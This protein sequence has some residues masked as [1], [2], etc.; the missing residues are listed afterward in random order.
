MRSIQRSVLLCCKPVV[1]ASHAPGSGVG[2]DVWVVQSLKGF[3][4]SIFLSSPHLCSNM[5]I[6]PFVLYIICSLVASSLILCNIVS[7]AGFVDFRRALCM[8]ALTL[9]GTGGGVDET[10]PP[11]GFSGI[12]FLFTVRLSPFFL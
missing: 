1:F 2:N 6:L 11:C 5:L 8:H 9:A 3:Q 7:I 12:S 4:V 10:P